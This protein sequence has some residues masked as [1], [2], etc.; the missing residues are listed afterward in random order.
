[1]QI[2]FIFLCFIFGGNFLSADLVVEPE[3]D[4]PVMHQGRLRPLSLTKLE[5]TDQLLLIP[6]KYK[7]SW[8]PLSDLDKPSPYN[9][10]RFSD[11][12]FQALKEAKKNQDSLK[13][14]QLLAA[15]AETNSRFA[16]EKFFYAAPWK[17]MAIG[18]YTL[19]G[20]FLLLNKRKE[21]LAFFTIAFL[22]HSLILFLRC[23]ILNRPPVSNMQET[24]IYVPW[25][26]ALLGLGWTVYLKDCLPALVGSFMAALLLLTPI[27]EGLENVQPVLNSRFWLIVH[28]MMIVASYG[29]LL[30]SGLVG[31]IYILTKSERAA[32][33]LLPS[34]YIG[35]ALLIPGTLLGGVWAAESWGRFW[36]WDPKESWAFISASV[37]LI[38]IH[39]KRYGKIDTFGLAIGSIIGLMAISFTWYGVNYILGTGLHSYGFG[40]GGE[41]YYWLFIAFEILIISI[42]IIVNSLKNKSA[43]GNK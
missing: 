19:A 8:H 13:I 7:E 22:L 15:S 32:R 29:V 34:L 39:A 43:Y 18:F 27:N 3:K 40:S 1:M 24:V 16:A 14:K 28:V 21:G 42:S 20:L 5:F 31:H 6:D 33:I 10:S 11:E 23:Y 17:V 30:F 9:F 2:L 12:T 25:I 35:V 37:Y 4:I 38:F 36:D 41:I 26:G